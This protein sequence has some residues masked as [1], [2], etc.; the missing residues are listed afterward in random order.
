MAKVYR[1][2]EMN[3][4]T[5][6]TKNFF[7]QNEMF[8]VKRLPNGHFKFIGGNREVLETSTCQHFNRDDEN[9]TVTITTR[10]SMI[11]FIPVID[12]SEWLR[13]N[14]R[15]G[16]NTADV[17]YLNG[18]TAAEIGAKIAYIA[19]CH[20]YTLKSFKTSVNNDKCNSMLFTVTRGEI[21]DDDYQ[22]LIFT[23]HIDKYEYIGT[24]AKLRISPWEGEGKTIS[25]AGSPNQINKKIKS[26]LA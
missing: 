10:N 9:G 15:A 18:L 20:G 25:L 21:F 3:T 2:A 23:V 16:H 5:E 22:S 4:T 24:S 1:L 8:F 13:V 19:I 14:P 6:A 11:K 7:S 12:D 17:Q 26:L